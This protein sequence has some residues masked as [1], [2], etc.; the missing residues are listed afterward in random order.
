[1]TEM[2]LRKVY[3]FIQNYIERN[4]FSP[5]FKEISEGCVLHMWKVLDA[6]SIL[7]SR[8]KVEREKGVQRSIRIVS[9]AGD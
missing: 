8:G 1:M 9:N 6:V 5:S 7:E 3:A 2:I 4:H